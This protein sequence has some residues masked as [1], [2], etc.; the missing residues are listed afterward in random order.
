[1]AFATAQTRLLAACLT[2]L[3]FFLP[4]NDAQA[5]DFAA[6]KGQVILTV[7]G[8]VQAH[9][10]ADALQLDIDQLAALPQHSFTTSTVWTVG[11]STFTG[12]LLK[13][14]MAAVGAKGSIVTLTALNDYQVSFPS[15][16]MSDDGPMLAYLQDG[17]PMTVRD[18]GPIWLV[19]PYDD[20]PDYRSELAY[21]RSI[22]QL[23]RI[24][25]GD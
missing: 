24:S 17:K 21:S 19:Y 11:K 9:N 20:N 6:A 8:N 22:W 13:D 25:F 16:D 7:S 10:T 1:M 5:G 2:A 3:S 14:F 18:K 23:D 12:V 15:T 4:L